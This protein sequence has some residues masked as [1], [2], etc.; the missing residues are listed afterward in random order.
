[1]IAI[2]CPSFYDAIR[3]FW[4]FLSMLQQECVWCVKKV[5]ES[6]YCV[7]TDDDLRY[8]FVDYRM[9]DVFKKMNADI[10]DSE[11]FFEFEWGFRVEGGYL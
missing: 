7:E 3:D 4:Y 8:I 9:E 1:M 6:E 2:L 11:T 5:Y 10:I